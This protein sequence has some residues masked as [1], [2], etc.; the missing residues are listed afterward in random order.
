MDLRVSEKRIERRNNESVS[1]NY[2]MLRGEMPA[3]SG[4]NSRIS[5]LMK[6]RME[7]QVR[8]S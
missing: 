1:A 4:G 3:A 5:S 7:G 6:T 2:P 8:F